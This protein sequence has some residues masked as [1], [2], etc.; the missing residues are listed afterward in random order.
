[1]FP[2]EL[3]VRKRHNTFG[4]DKVLHENKVSLKWKLQC[5]TYS[6]FLEEGNVNKAL[7]GLNISIKAIQRV[8]I[9]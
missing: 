3:S 8:Q 7:I 5:C 2:G 4:G 9:S 1:M 6:S